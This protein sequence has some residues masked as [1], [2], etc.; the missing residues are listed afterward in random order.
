MTADGEPSSNDTKKRR[1]AANMIAVVGAILIT[2][3]LVHIIGGLPMILE[4]AKNGG[5]NLPSIEDE[6]AGFQLLREP[7]VYGILSLGVDRIILGVI[8][9]LCVPELKK[10]SKFAWRICVAIG[11]L[12]LVGNTPLVYVSF[13][14]VHVLPLIMPAFGL[15]IL[16]ALLVGRRSFGGS[17]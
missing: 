10:G 16:V 1:L 13:E 14:R 11:L 15:I 4:A 5:I 2:L 8:L 6:V 12:L 17:R 3:G 9:L 7:V